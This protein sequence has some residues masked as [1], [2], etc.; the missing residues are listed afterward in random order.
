MSDKKLIY[1]ALNYFIATVWIINGFFCKAL[2]L[3][4]RHQLIV[5]RILGAEHAAIFTKAI[6]IAEVCMALWI[7]SFRKS[8]LCA[9]TQLAIVATMNTLEFFL[10]PDLLLFGKA[11]AFFAFVFI[12]MIY[13]NEFIL[14]KKFASQS[15]L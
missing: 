3:V 7:L 15:S 4:P 11:N 13:Y 8:R 12:G 1:I 6:G 14:N 5:S 9:I 10:A 2:N